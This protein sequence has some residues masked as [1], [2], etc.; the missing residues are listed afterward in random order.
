MISKKLVEHIVNRADR[1]CLANFAKDIITDEIERYSWD[2]EKVNRMLEVIVDGKCYTADD[3][4]LDKL[5]EAVKTSYKG[6]NATDITVVGVHTCTNGVN[7][8]Y[9][10]ED[11]TYST[12]IPLTNVL[13]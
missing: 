7:V 12:E 8:T 1:Q 5:Q 10:S 2:D 9:K 13:K 11:S 6:E 4:D 3:I